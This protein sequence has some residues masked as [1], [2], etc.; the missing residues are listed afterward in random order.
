MTKELD[1]ISEAE[2]EQHEQY[3]HE[4]LESTF[5]IVEIDKWWEELLSQDADYVFCS[6]D[7]S[8]VENSVDNSEFD[9]D[10]AREG[11]PWG[12]PYAANIISNKFRNLLSYNADQNIWYLWN[13]I[14]H[15]PMQNAMAAEEIMEK[16]LY[17][18]ERAYDY[19][20]DFVLAQAEQIKAEKGSKDGEN[21]AEKHRKAFERLFKKHLSF[22]DRLRPPDGR[23][24]VIADL[25]RKL[26]VSPRKF[27]D[28]TDWFVFRNGVLDCKLLRNEG[29]IRWYRHSPHR[30]VTR[31]FDADYDLETNLG[32]WDE[33]IESSIP[34]EEVRQYVQACVGAAFSGNTKLRT[35]LIFDGERSSGKSLFLEVLAELGRRNDPELDWSSYTNGNANPMSILRAKGVRNFAQAEF[36]INRIVGVSEP[37]VQE[38]ID[39]EFLKAYTGDRTVSTEKKHKDYH[40]DIAQGLLIIA[41]NE[42][43]KINSM[44]TAVMKRAKI[45]KFPYSFVDNPDSAKET[46]KK[47]VENLGEL[48]L[49]DRSSVL[50]WII[51]GMYIHKNEHNNQGISYNR[52][53]DS[54]PAIMNNWMKELKDDLQTP[55]TWLKF[56]IENG[57]ID[58]VQNPVEIAGRANVDMLRTS[59]AHRVYQLWCDDNGITHKKG[60]RVFTKM[61][62]DEYGISEFPKVQTKDYSRFPILYP[63][64]EFQ[65]YLIE[66][67]QLRQG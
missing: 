49:E 55:I 14:I 12:E 27:E 31:F 26:A 34:D 17:A 30:N 56:M 50:R 15:A 24:R 65:K 59:E 45:V 19:V 8:I 2:I 58:Y 10:K 67:N 29:E 66:A 21:E 9:I 60:A 28:D 33:F 1:S 23:N 5:E 43:P 47:S 25:K 42:M 13:G 61:I 11:L 37:N 7:S 51:E 40:V 44:D 46:E 63:T 35:F 62:M 53:E 54:A 16:F 36:G 32:Y 6:E 57:S 18:Y 64:P 22:R 39:G 3:I 52:L 20:E 41:T 4:I 48:I 38:E